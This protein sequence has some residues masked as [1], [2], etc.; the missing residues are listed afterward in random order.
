MKFDRPAETNP[1]DRLRVVGRAHPRIDGPLKTTGK[2]TYAYEHHDVVTNPA[3]GV[4]VGS[5][6]AK[7]RIKSM[8]LAE[9]QREPGV[10]AIVTAE[11]AG[12]LG[13]GKFNTAKLLGG[14]E[15]DHYHQAVA[16]V[17]A[18]TFEQATAAAGLL[19]IEYT[20]CEG[21]FDLEEALKAAPLAKDPNSPEKQ[22]PPESRV[23]DFEPAFA[24]APVKLDE[25][26]TTP[27]QTI[28]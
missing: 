13:K 26:Y 12:K 19:R 20:P 1:I 8:N 23:G 2:A 21:S 24:Q 15:I 14:P 27:D 10:I 11:S 5:A 17:V 25:F 9:A 16:V 3:Y 7:G 22:G 28:R 18:E 4:I 6:I